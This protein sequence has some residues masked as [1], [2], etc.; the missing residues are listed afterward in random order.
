[1]LHLRG[2]VMIELGVLDHGEDSELAVTDASHL[3]ISAQGLVPLCKELVAVLDAREQGRSTTGVA[4]PS[5]NQILLQVADRRR[6]RHD[7]GAEVLRGVDAAADVRLLDENDGRSAASH[8][9]DE[10]E[11]AC[12]GR[13]AIVEGH[14]CAIDHALLVGGAAAIGSTGHVGS[15][16]V[17]IDM[18][19]GSG[20][21]SG[22]DAAAKAAAGRGGEG[23]E[24]GRAEDLGGL[25]PDVGGVTEAHLVGDRL[26]RAEKE[27][28]LT[29]RQREFC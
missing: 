20:L 3:A 1:M 17:V 25:R 2:T 10:A 13:L 7:G 4:R 9:D 5:T 16:S 6:R 15:E 19:E 24:L 12:P 26:V 27:V 22:G 28:I 21:Q 23:V 14:R 29:S 8:R 18:D 11:H